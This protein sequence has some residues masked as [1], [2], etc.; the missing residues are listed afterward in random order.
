MKTVNYQE[1][2]QELENAK[3]LLEKKTCVPG[4][5][6]TIWF[7]NMG[8]YDKVQMGINISGTGNVSS[9]YAKR[10]AYCIETAA[11]II[12]NFKYNG[13]TVR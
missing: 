1:Y 5:Y 11:E 7:V 12:A 9:D 10:F 8:S 6:N 3:A 2:Q 13:Y 4:I